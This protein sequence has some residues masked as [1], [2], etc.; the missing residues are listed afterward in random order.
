MFPMITCRTYWADRAMK[1]FRYKLALFGVLYA[2]AA[3]AQQP[4]GPQ[5]QRTVQQSMQAIGGDWQS[6]MTAQGHVVAGLQELQ[7]LATDLER[8][9]AAANAENAK[10]KAENEKLK[11]ETSKK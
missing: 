1:T 8:K 3:N 11:V 5:P 6:M 7:A 10:L 2:S 4:P 9:L